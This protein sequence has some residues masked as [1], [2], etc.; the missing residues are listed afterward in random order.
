MIRATWAGVAGLA[1]DDDLVA[2]LRELQDGVGEHL[3]ELGPEDVEVGDDLDLEV[4]GLARAGG[5]RQVGR[6]QLLA[7]QA[8]LPGADLEE[9]DHARVAHREEGGGL[10]GDRQAS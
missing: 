9:V 5:D 2:D 1:L 3:A 4:V 7:D 10:P 6:P 8:E